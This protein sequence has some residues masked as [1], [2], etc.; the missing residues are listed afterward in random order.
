MRAATAGLAAHLA[1]EVTTLATC[2]RVERTDGAVF[3]FTSH[4]RN[5]TVDG[6]VYEAATGITRSA[7][8]AH[9]G[10]AVDNAEAT[11]FLDA[12]AIT[13]DD[14]R[15]GAW[16]HAEVRVFEVN[17]S[18]LSQG[19]LRQ[20]RGWLGE[21]TVEGGRYKCELR[22]MLAALN[23]NVIEE[24]TPGCRA[25]L[26]DARCTVDVT[27]YTASGEV[28]TVA[29]DR[30]FSTDLAAQTVALT[31]STTGAPPAGYFDGGLLTWATGANAGR[32]A[33]VRSSSAG[34]ELVLQLAMSAP[35]EVGDTFVCVAGC[36]K[37]VATCSA[38]FDNVVNMRAHPHLPGMDQLMRVGGQ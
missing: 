3:G 17:W 14:I 13:D 19:T 4:D 32:S 18:D 27:P 1:Q 10:L 23:V 35:V 15:A 6:L 30:E 2:W 36:K 29:S 28:F 25:R 31:P 5:L 12:D 21:I 11:G 7:L 9:A 22:G 24:F 34:G 26:G 8:E 33:E 37:D 16:D 38:K 20:L